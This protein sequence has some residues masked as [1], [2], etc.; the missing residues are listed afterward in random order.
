MVGSSPDNQRK[1][2]SNGANG[3]WSDI[4]RLALSVGLGTAITGSFGLGNLVITGSQKAAEERCSSARQI[5]IDDS[6]SPALNEG[7]RR[8]LGLLAIQALEECLGESP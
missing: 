6:A 8:R 1:R 4:G 7:Q 3:G 2:E 5:V